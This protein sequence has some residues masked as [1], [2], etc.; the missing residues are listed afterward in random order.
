MNNLIDCCFQGNI[1]YL[2]DD[3]ALNLLAAKVAAV[4]GDVRKALDVARCAVDL[5]ENK[6][7]SSVLQ[8][9]SNNGKI[10]FQTLPFFHLI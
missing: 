5:A 4:S 9:S 3:N 8:P 6:S 2:L 1:S 7:K 10:N